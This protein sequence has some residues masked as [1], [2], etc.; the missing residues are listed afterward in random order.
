MNELEGLVG[1]VVEEVAADE[2]DRHLDLG[3]AGTGHGDGLVEQVDPGDPPALLGQVYREDSG[4]AADVEGA[5]GATV[6]RRDQHPVG[7]LPVPGQ[8]LW[9]A[10]GP[11]VELP[12]NDLR[13]LHRSYPLLSRDVGV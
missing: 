3:G 5:A 8:P 1:G 2:L 9:V 6:R 11:T 7:L 13:H 10:I 12:H 4:A